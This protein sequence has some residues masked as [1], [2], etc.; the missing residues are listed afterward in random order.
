MSEAVMICGARLRAE[1]GELLTILEHVH[2]MVHRGYLFQ[3]EHAADVANNANLD[4]LLTT[5]SKEAHIRFVIPAGGACRVYLYEATTA[6]SGTNV[7]IINLRRLSANTPET[8]IVHGPTVGALGTALIP[9][10][11]LPGGASPTTRIG[12]EV[13]DQAELVLKPNTK[14][15]LRT[16]NV[17][18]GTI[19][20]N[21]IISF[22]EHNEE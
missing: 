9:G 19:T 3:A 17:S 18:G 11:F 14:H 13:R 16:Q 22:Y 10:R 15:L 1:H 4:V 21:P 6:S 12:G 20:I 5:G 7:S 8:V 2:W